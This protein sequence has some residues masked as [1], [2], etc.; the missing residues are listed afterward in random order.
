MQARPKRYFRSVHVVLTAV[1]VAVLFPGIC[2]KG[3]PMSYADAKQFLSEHTEVI[4]LV[5]G[6]ARVAVCPKWQGRVMTSTSGGPQGPSFGFINRAFIES[7]KLDPK[8]NN[9]GGEDRLWLSPEGGQFSLWFAPGAEQNLDNWYTP[10]ALNEATMSV[11]AQPTARS[12]R[13]T[14][15][16]A[17]GNAS[18]TQ[19]KLDVV[20]EVRLLGRNDLAAM[21]GPEA[22]ALLAGEDVKFVAY[23]TANT[24]T[25]RGEPMT[26]QDGLVSI[27][28]LSM[29][30]ATPQTVVIVPYKQ[31]DEAELGPVVKSDYFGPV[32]PERLKVTPEA[33]L[34]LGDGAFRSKIGTSQKRAKE[35]AGAFGF[36]S[37]TLTLAHFTMP[38]DP[39]EYDYMN[40]SWELPQAEPYV[41]DVMNS[42][43]DGPP[44]P[45][46]KGMGAFYEI[47][48]LSPAAALAPGRSLT[49]SHRTVHIRADHETLAALSRLVLGVELAEVRRTML[50]E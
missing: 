17:F 5:D 49:H 28:I 26:K 16:M 37:G 6:D 19:F 47:E 42:Y 9:Y 29:L 22:A 23:E 38:E 35:V 8:F 25:N 33:I 32:P 50:A 18:G 20:R 24:I 31:G 3:E 11:A 36:D 10:P 13:M 4:E 2:A 40:N 34:F 43:N 14:Q 1:L 46:Q 39:S 15:Q 21:F 45:G 41:G 27:W 44:E 7:G 48:S 30:N 12:I